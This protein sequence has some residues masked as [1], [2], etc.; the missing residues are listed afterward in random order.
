M[1]WEK[2][3]I[4]RYYTAER[5]GGRVVKSYVGFGRVAELA[6][7]LDEIK[8]QERE[9]KA[10]EDRMRRKELD[11]LEAALATFDELAD[12]LAA[13]AMLVAGY[14]RHNQGEWRKRR[15]NQ[16]SDENAGAR[17]D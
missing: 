2:R 6:A 14:R 10:F 17:A 11:E 8:R 3:G 15:V 5:I 4:G 13:A 1:S 12:T 7:Q 9:W 16:G